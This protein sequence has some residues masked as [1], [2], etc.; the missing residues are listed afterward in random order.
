MFTMIQLYDLYSFSI[1]KTHKHISCLFFLILCATMTAFGQPPTTPPASTGSGRAAY[2][3]AEELRKQNRCGDAIVKYEEAIKAEPNN[4]KYFFQKGLCEYKEKK[5]E[6]AKASYTKAIELN[7]EFTS[8]YAQMARIAKDQKDIDN[9]IYYYEQAALNERSPNRRIQYELILVNLLLK[10]DKQYEAKK[11]LEE[12]GKVDPGNMNVQYYTG[13]MKAAENDW[14]GARDEYTKATENPDFGALPPAE[15]AKY[16]YAQGLAFSKLNDLE[17][18]K[19]SWAKAN[20]SPWSQLIQQQLMKSNHLYY[21]KVALSYYL[22]SEFEESETNIKKC[23][24]IQP[25]YTGGF[26]LRGKIARKQNDMRSAIEY[27]Q[28]ATDLE[29]DPPKKQ[30]LQIATANLQMSNNDNFGALATLDEAL[31]TVP[32]SPNTKNILYMKAR[33]QYG[34]GRFDDAIS[35]LNTLL[36]GA[37]ARSK[38]K[39]AFLLGMAAKKGGQLDKAKTAFQNAMFGPYK[40]AARIELDKLSGKQE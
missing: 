22:N 4:Y 10:Q 9:T 38:A 14:A 23:L 34:S 21:Y 30:R 7:K 3:N 13:E 39:Y 16:Y 37:D 12:A 32:N 26:E 11:H 33:A 6:E 29:K 28:K 20:F 18:A 24:E 25:D 17:N 2:L 36:E 15:K 1:M 5:I 35:S 8:S 40:P 31:A 27:Y 19:K